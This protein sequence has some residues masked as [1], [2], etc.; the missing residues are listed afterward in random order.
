[1]KHYFGIEII[2][3]RLID[4]V[5]HVH[6]KIIPTE[7]MSYNIYPY[8]IIKDQIHRKQNMKHFHLQA[9]GHLAFIFFLPQATWKKNICK[10]RY[11]ISVSSRL[12]L[13]STWLY[14]IYYP[15]SRFTSTTL[16]CYFTK[17]RKKNHIS[18]SHDT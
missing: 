4:I 16:T 11:R 12:N 1:M 3:K 6:Y 10:M 7:Y 17:L 5:I 18:A 14:R 8:K 9:L 15:Y 13:E 2:H